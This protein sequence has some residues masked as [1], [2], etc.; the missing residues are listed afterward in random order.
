MR[1]LILIFLIML[2]VFSGV[3]GYTEYTYDSIYASQSPSS[4]N[5]IDMFDNDLGS[6]CQWF[7]TFNLPGYIGVNYTS[8]HIINVFNLSSVDIA[9]PVSGTIRGSLDP[10]IYGW[11]T[12]SS[13][14]EVNNWTASVT[15]K[16]FDFSNSVAYKYYSIN[17]TKVNVTQM[18][19]F[20]IKL[21]NITSFTPTPL[22]IFSVNNTIGISPLPIQFTDISNNTPLSWIYQ[23]NNKTGN[24]TWI[25]FSTL[26]NPV[27]AFGVGNYSINL[28][29]AN[30]GN[31]NISTQ[32]TYI[33]VSMYIPPSPVIAHHGVINIS[34]VSR[35]A[36]YINF[37]WN[38][39]DSTLM[40]V[41]GYKVEN[42][43]LASASFI[44]SNLN[45]M[46]QH[47]LTVYNSTQDGYLLSNT[48][49]AISG[50]L[51][52]ATI[53]N[54][55]SIPFNNFMA[56]ILEYLIMFTAIALLIIGIRVPLISMIGFLFA[57][58]GLIDTLIKG[59]FILDM[60]FIIL[61]LACCLITYVG[62]KRI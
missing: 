49:S 45:P 12:L 24:N 8:P 29:T 43:D 44:L 3:K 58:A 17:I 55:G 53:N 30:A 18:V 34:I 32:L 33:N 11:T 21:L 51:I 6:Y 57:F 25:T 38:N 36:T 46:E 22:S 42:F 5:L 20:E 26:Q 35:G 61:M 15:S 4:G 40:Y 2:F 50:M 56:F 31:K 16:S 23:F 7:T 54:E 13:F 9:T 52:N 48:T 39:N 37:A 59:N 10:A 60:M 1:K 41:D 14:S 62:V 19:I 28:T 27:Y 47:S